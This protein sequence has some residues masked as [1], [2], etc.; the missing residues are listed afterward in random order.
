MS[1][2]KATNQ[3]NKTETVTDT[4][5]KLVAAREERCGAQIEQVRHKLP[6]IK[7]MS[8]EDEMYT[9]RIQSTRRG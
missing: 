4:E 8:H 9:Q 2:N 7:Y 5:S 6:A 1:K 3:H